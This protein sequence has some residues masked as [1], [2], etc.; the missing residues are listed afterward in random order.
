MLFAI[1]GTFSMQQHRLTILALPYAIFAFTLVGSAQIQPR[2]FVGYDSFCG[3]P[4]IVGHDSQ[5]ATAR[6]DDQGN[7]FIHLDR[8][9]MAD[10]T[11]SRMFLLA[12]ECAHH[13]LGHTS[14]LGQLQ[15]Y[16]GGTRRQELEADCWAAKE[17][18]SIGEFRSL[19]RTVLENLNQGHFSQGGYPTGAERASNISVCAEGHRVQCSHIMPEHQGDLYPCRHACLGPY[20]LVPCHPQGDA[21]PCTHLVPH[22]PYHVIPCTHPAHLGG[23]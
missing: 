12:H 15:R 21:G 5:M 14:S 1:L 18:S 17:L 22:H 9:V 23:H 13:L 11:A 2:M 20:G 6:L 8:G 7:P 16:M 10:W 3:L 4:V 19:R